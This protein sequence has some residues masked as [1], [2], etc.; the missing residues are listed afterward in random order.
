[1]SRSAPEDLAR[2]WLRPDV[3]V[4]EVFHAT[5]DGWQDEALRAFPTTSRIA[6]KASK[7]PG[8]TA[9]LAWMAWNYLL[10][11]PHP[12]ISAVSINSPNLRDNLWKEMAVWRNK[13]PLLQAT[14]EWTAERI[15]HKQHRETWWMSARSWS[16]SSDREQLGNTLAGLHSKYVMAIMDESGAMPPEIAQ[17]A[18]GIFAGSD[19]AHIIQA[20]NTNT[21]EGAL[22]QACVRNKAL[23]RVIVISGDPDDPNRST[24]VPIDWARDMI[25]S[26]P[27]GRDSPFIKVLLLGE[28]PKQSVNAL[29][30]PDEVEA[31]MKRKYQQHHT[32]H[33]ARIL[34][35]DV[36][37]EGDDKS[38][39]FP[40]QG[41]VAFKPHVMRNVTGIVGAGQ[42]ARTWE[43]WNVDAC[44]IDNTGG[45]GSSWI[46]VLSTLNRSAIP[47]GFAEGAQD[48]RYANRRAEMYYR[49]VD[50]I[51]SGGALP[52]TGCE[53]LIGELSQTTYTFKGDALQLE[54]KK[55]I[56]AKLGR[57]PD[58]ADALCLTFAEPVAK[59]TATVLPMSQNDGSYDPFSDLMKVR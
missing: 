35:V 12:N 47:I 8:K 59:R 53:D 16:Q 7:G 38:V 19:E 56:K 27:D 10:T 28:W 20:G 15:F 13:S 4:R 25:A 44:F 29:I 9:S 50:W 40:R 48:K 45:F 39:I 30:G 51:R 34:G 22:Y 49:L 33:A 52:P 58:L 37:R 43:D 46:D 31:A 26:T 17:S 18:E 14:F 1:M 24:R 36:A 3:M 11:R 23:W 6:M 42:V 54:D 57:S 55:L 5:P 21:L 2:W 41:L 32:D